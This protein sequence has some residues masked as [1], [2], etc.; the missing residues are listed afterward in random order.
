MN[1]QQELEAFREMALDEQDRC[2]GLSELPDPRE[3]YK[4][5]DPLLETI[6]QGRRISLSGSVVVPV[7]NDSQSII[8][9]AI[10]CEPV[11]GSSNGIFASIQQDNL[12][13]IPLSRMVIGYSAVLR[14]LRQGNHVSY[15]DTKLLAFAPLESCQLFIPE[16]EMPDFEAMLPDDEDEIAQTID[17]IVLN[18][19]INIANLCEVF[20][21][22]AGG[23][24]MNIEFY[25]NYLNY[26]FDTKSQIFS[27]QAIRAV[28]V[29]FTN[30]D[31]HET[32]EED[33]GL[34][35][36]GAIE[37][38]R[39]IIS[40]GAALLCME[41]GQEDYKDLKLLIPVESIIQLSIN[42]VEEAG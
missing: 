18:S 24:S 41:I 16:A 28:F 35:F 12:S 10:S 36:E 23:T 6:I 32:L 21:D 33:E 37:G 20:N 22:L 25:L 9:E 40:N 27:L 13:G 34:D 31:S 42:R 19:P 2:N 1:L 11:E 5:L 26:I 14:T 15:I 17:E 39:C 4:L 38:F 29:D 30:G 3:L 7:L 8:G